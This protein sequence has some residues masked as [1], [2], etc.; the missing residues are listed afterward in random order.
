MTNG[1]TEIVLLLSPKSAP[2]RSSTRLTSLHQIAGARR[3]AFTM[4]RSAATQI[5]GAGPR[6][7]PQ[8]PDGTRNS[9]PAPSAAMSDLPIRTPPQRRLTDGSQRQPCR[10]CMTCLDFPSCRDGCVA[11]TVVE[12][13]RDTLRWPRFSLPPRLVLSTWRPKVPRRVRS[14]ARLRFSCF[15]LLQPRLVPCSGVAWAS[16]PDRFSGLCI[17]ASILS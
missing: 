6:S 4:H 12:P 1:T 3:E 11:E 10:L 16:Y 5:I 15:P 8:H 9:P 17:F 14:K 13:V 7:R 2:M